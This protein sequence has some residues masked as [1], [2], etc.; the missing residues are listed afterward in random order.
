MAEMTLDQQRAMAMAAARARAA[1]A[2]TSA[3]PSGDIPGPRRSYSMT[4]VPVE[5]VWTAR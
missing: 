3:A 5:A 4:E 2:E 1:Q